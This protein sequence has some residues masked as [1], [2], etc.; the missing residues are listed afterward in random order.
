MAITSLG[1]GSGL[2]LESIIEQLMQ[3]EQ[4]P[5][6]LLASKE[7][8]YNTKLSA[9]SQL[10]SSVSSFQSVM[11]SL[12]SSSTY[13]N[14]TG[15]VSDE[16]IASLT[17]SSKAS[18]GSYSLFVKQLA[19]AQKLAAA[20]QAKANEAIGGGSITIEFGKVSGGTYDEVTGKY[21]GAS[22]EANDSGAKS[23]DIAADS[24][25][26]DIR[27]AI[28]AAGVGVTASIV[29]DGKENP[30]RLVLTS[31]ETGEEQSM[32]ITVS[33]DA[34]Q[35]LKDLL[36]HDPAE[37]A[38]QAM[39]QTVKA[40]NAI[41][42]L[43][44]IEIT[45]SKNAVSDAITGVTL[46]LLA[47]SEKASTITVKQDTSGAKTA[48]ENFVGA[49]NTLVN[50]LKSMT[51]YD[52][53]KKAASVLTG[54]SAVRSVQTQLKSVFSQVL[55][56]EVGYRMLSDIGITLD[57]DGVLN[58]DN[59]KLNAALEKDF[60][61]F[62]GM[63][64]E[65]GI[66]GTDNIEFE[67]QADTTKPGSYEVNIRQVATKGYSALNVS[68]LDLSGIASESGR[69]ISVNLH[70]V[71]KAITLDQRNYKSKEEF[72]AD[73]QS[74]INAEY[75]DSGV[76]VNVKVDDDGNVRVESNTYGSVSTV[77]IGSASFFSEA[78][79]EG[80]K[81]VAGTIDGI[82]ADG[83]GQFLTAKSGDAAGMKL[84]I[85]GEEGDV[86]NGTVT[87]TQGFAYQFSEIAKT[88][89]EDDGVIDSR[90]EGVNKS[91]E[92]ISKQYE[93]WD[94]R[95]TQVE[96]A[97]RAKFTALDVLLA[98]MNSTSSYLTTQLA[99]LSSLWNQ[100]KSK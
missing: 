69:S 76:N 92:S 65:G 63:F 72:A 52:P 67:S 54:D 55:G 78:S 21:T 6:A 85:T 75:K 61:A 1:V 20:G 70:G 49:Y 25:L 30:Y 45:K 17:A 100:S 43:D 22:F 84:K 8:S 31:N 10:K 26:E 24:T 41:F 60:Q 4:R 14:T 95:L 33:D 68:N 11:N 90:I 7:S 82:E 62:V 81:D 86:I 91:L 77:S 66:S 35:A 19:Q 34:D 29:N 58:I 37:D 99:T 23:V 15:S 89:L 18:S 42:T 27:D 80:G 40:Q 74:K 12:S 39:Q 97:Y 44:G 2:D 57:K 94:K 50:S 83:S 88:M 13:Q 71:A 53:E 64:V 9:Y 98:E 16:S 79:S 32:R 48:V 96:A 5:V 38:G 73:L 51:A 56:G 3:V 59:T 28:N 87:F 93:N 47:E 46:T 36:N